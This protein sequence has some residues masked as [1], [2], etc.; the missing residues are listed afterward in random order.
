[1][2]KQLKIW[3]TYF[4]AV[5]S[6]DKSFEVRKD[7]RGLCV[8]DTVM[9]REFIPNNAGGGEYTGREIAKTISYIVRG[10]QWGID[11]DTCVFGW[12]SST[13]HRLIQD[14]EAARAENKALREAQEW[15][16]THRDKMH[17]LEV[18]VTSKTNHHVF[19][20]QGKRKR[21]SDQREIFEKWY[22]PIP[23][24]EPADDPS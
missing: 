21:T 20:E 18:R 22:V 11:G 19:Y 4:E 1:M 7:D 5:L 17:G 3:P 14:L 9:L 2:T 13:M 24:T 6:G 8:G 23:T 15:K 10:S 16:P 12:K